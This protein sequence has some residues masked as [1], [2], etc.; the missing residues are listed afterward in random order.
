[1]DDLNEGLLR[2][3]AFAGVFAVMAVLE[4]IRPRRDLNHSKRD[5]WITNLTIGG[6]DSVMLRLM[7]LLAVP[8]A[9]MAAA[10]Y[11]ETRGWGLFHGT[12]WPLWLEILLAVVLLDLAIY[13]Q[14]VASHKI[15]VLWR[16]HRVHHSDVDIDVTT[17]IR[18]HPIEIALS[19]LYKIVVVLAIGAHPL[20]VLAF[21]VILNGCAMFNH[22]NIDLPRPLD[23]L[24]R[25]AVVTPDMHRV[26]HSVLWRETD[27]NY[28]FNL[29]LWDRLFGTYRAQPE[30]GHTGM[31]I[32][33]DGCQ[34]ARPTGLIWSLAFP[35]RR[36]DRRAVGRQAQRSVDPGSSRS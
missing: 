5:R 19:M 12:D 27:S 4:L 29:S 3:G 13:G 22:S 23:R 21:E 25:L 35:F 36:G 28:G 32:G 8:L 33:L 16:L 1:M 10:V 20:A 9:A 34:D 26:H 31:T 7:A 24:L 14:H 6:I 11:A 17:A 15:P 2:F 18:F 30:R